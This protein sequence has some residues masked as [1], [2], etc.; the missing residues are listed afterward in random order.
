MFSS[1]FLSLA[2]RCLVVPYLSAF[3]VVNG[4]FGVVG[5]EEYI[6]R[7]RLLTENSHKPLVEF[8][9]ACMQENVLPLSHL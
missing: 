6:F 3:M 4:I 5:R 1:S 7:E 9:S 2:L 8:S